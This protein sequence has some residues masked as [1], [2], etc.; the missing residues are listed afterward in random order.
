MTDQID[1]AAKSIS[2]RTLLRGATVALPTVMTLKS[3]AALAA[4]SNLMGT[5]RTA[6]EAVGEGGRVQCLDAA[7]A[8]GGTTARLDLGTDPMLHV[9][10][11]T[12]RTYYLGNSNNTAGDPNKPVTIDRM[13]RVGGRYW[14]RDQGW[15]QISVGYNRRGIE[16]GFLVSATA[17]ASFSSAIKVKSVF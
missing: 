6:S 15:R 13:C 11:V 1:T 17:L 10:Y 8:E 5:V 16:A 14:Y 9:Q 12:P 4:S 2:R 7:S 3:G